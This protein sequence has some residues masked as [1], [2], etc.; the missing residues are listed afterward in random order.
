[1]EERCIQG[2][3]CRLPTCWQPETG[4]LLS[5]PPRR[6]APSENQ[7][8]QVCEVAR[9][10]AH[11]Y[12]WSS[13]GL[14]GSIRKGVQPGPATVSDLPVIPSFPEP[15]TELGLSYSETPCPRKERWEPSCSAASRIS[16]WPS[17]E[18]DKGA[19][20]LPWLCEVPAAWPGPLASYLLCA[21]VN[22]RPEIHWMVPRMYAA[23]W[24]RK[25]DITLSPGP[26][27]GSHSTKEL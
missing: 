9:P 8:K 17:S 25:A 2:D 16:A 14:L 5:R 27:S 11:S 4:Q 6:R 18:H 1:M 3:P 21:A 15:P 20:A 10:G 19:L 24:G 13:D 12:F 23:R 7:V 22:L 26:S